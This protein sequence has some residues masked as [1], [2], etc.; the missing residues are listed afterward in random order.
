MSF[1]VRVYTTFCGGIIGHCAAMTAA[2]KCGWSEPWE[3]SD[4]GKRNP[5]ERSDDAYKLC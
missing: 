3:R 2:A 4:L 1:N 5:E